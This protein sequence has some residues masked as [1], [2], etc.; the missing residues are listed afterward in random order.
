MPFAGFHRGLDSRPYDLHSS[1]LPM[2]PLCGGYGRSLAKGRGKL[3]SRL[4]PSLGTIGY[5]DGTSE[6]QW[7]IWEAAVKSKLEPDHTRSLET[8]VKKVVIF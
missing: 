1:I 6:M 5:T 8:V 3:V 7:N 2:A 4:L